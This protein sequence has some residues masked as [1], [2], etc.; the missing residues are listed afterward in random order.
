MATTPIATR[1]ELA[2]HFGVS[3]LNEIADDL[4]DDYLGFVD[5]LERDEQEQHDPLEHLAEA[6]RR[7]AD[8]A[9]DRIWRYAR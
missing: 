2:E 5:A 9:N 3:D 4:Y 6:F 8:E 1:T 7:D